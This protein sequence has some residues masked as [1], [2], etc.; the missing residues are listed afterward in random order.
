[1]KGFIEVTTQGGNRFILNLSNVVDF[2]ERKEDKQ[3]YVGMITSMH[4]VITIKESYE[5]IKQ[6]IINAQ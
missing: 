6:L 3:V 2:A 1:M 4:D 5:E